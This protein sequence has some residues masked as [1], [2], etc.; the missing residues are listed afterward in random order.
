MALASMILGIVGLVLCFILVPSLLA[1]IFGLIAAGR[2]RRSAGAVTGKGLARAGWIMGIIGLLVGGAF[3][4]AA[5]GGAFDDGE[6]AVFELERGDCVNFDFNPDSEIVVTVT[7]VDVVDCEKPHTAEVMFIDELNPDGDLPYPS[8]EQLFADIGEACSNRAPDEV[9]SDVDLTD[10]S[11]FTVAPDDGSWENDD[12][13]YVCFAIREG[14]R[15]ST[16]SLV[17]GAD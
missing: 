7:T 12:G 3:W 9:A 5:A 6:T 13:P 11:S 17:T 14:G 15:T 10:F 8:N 1:L 2:I 16:G 4:A